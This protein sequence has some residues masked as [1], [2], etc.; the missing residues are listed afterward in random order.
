MVV[1]QP[2][3]TSSVY[4]LHQLQGNKIHGYEKSGY[5]LKRSEGRMRKVWQRRKC[6]V[7][8]GMLS[9]GHSDVR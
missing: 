1:L 9:V 3:V 4:N 6:I 5:L 2:L 8:D 7:K